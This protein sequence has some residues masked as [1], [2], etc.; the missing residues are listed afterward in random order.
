MIRA[1]TSARQTPVANVNASTGTA[2]SRWK[3]S[4]INFILPFLNC[5]QSRFGPGAALRLSPQCVRKNFFSLGR[6][7]GA[8]PTIGRKAVVNWTATS[9]KIM[10]QTFKP[11]FE[12][13]FEWEKPV[14]RKRNPK[15]VAINQNTRCRI[16]IQT[17]DSVDWEKSQAT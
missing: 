17:S 16:P 13:A 15:K 3:A 1:E 6:N 12:R 9:M 7:V 11:A 14:S 4:L 8:L 10:I 5:V 2:V